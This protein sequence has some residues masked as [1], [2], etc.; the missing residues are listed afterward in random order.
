MPGKR[1]EI[2]CVWESRGG[3]EMMRIYKDWDMG[4]G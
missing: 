1:R 2:R 4:Y 3:N